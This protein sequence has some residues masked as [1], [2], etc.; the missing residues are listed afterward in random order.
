MTTVRALT[1]GQTRNCYLLR[2]F[3]RLASLDSGTDEKL[4]PTSSFFALG[5]FLSHM[6]EAVSEGTQLGLHPSPPPGCSSLPSS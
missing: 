4:L 3:S 2:R 1:L 5:L 6:E